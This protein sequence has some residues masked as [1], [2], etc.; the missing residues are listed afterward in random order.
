MSAGLKQGLRRVDRG[1]IRANLL[2]QFQGADC[3]WACSGKLR[4]RARG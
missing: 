3:C 4:H 2:A 1:R